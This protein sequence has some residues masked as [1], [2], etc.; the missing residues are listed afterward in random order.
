MKLIKNLIV[1]L[2]GIRVISGVLHPVWNSMPYPLRDFIKNKF[3]RSVYGFPQ[4]IEEVNDVNT[5]KIK[6]KKSS[7][8]PAELVANNPQIDFVKLNN[9]LKIPNK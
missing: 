1:Y 5:D 2:F 4:N 7:D 6:L 3:L 8:K 9:Y